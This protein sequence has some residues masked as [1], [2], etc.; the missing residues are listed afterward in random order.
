MIIPDN[1]N[2]ELV[3]YP[4]II[5]QKLLSLFITIIIIVVSWYLII[6]FKF[7]KI[8]TFVSSKMILIVSGI[9]NIIFDRNNQEQPVAEKSE[10]GSNFWQM[11]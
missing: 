5:I 4:L 3:T 10:A 11:W 7:T 1:N 2:I 9:S 8:K 6:F